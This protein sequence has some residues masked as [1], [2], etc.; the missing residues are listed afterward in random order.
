MNTDRGLLISF[1]GPPRSGRTY[2]ADRLAATLTLDGHDVVR[3]SMPDDPTPIAKTNLTWLQ[4]RMAA[5][6]S[7]AESSIR[8]AMERGAVVVLDGGVTS[9][10][11]RARAVMG[12]NVPLGLLYTFDVRAMREVPI[13]IEWIFLDVREGERRPPGFDC[14][15]LWR[16]A[17]CCH[18]RHAT[19]PDSTSCGGRRH[20]TYVLRAMH[21][22]AASEKFADIVANLLSERMADEWATAASE[23]REALDDAMIARRMEQWTLGQP[24]PVYGVLAAWTSYTDA[25]RLTIARSIPS[26][27]GAVERF[28]RVLTSLGVEQVA[29]EIN[30]V[31]AEKDAAETEPVIAEVVSI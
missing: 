6:A 12:A 4:E 17:A 28:V 9:A 13:D 25:Q 10:L 27:K 18:A 14:A 11:I 5:Y 16:A 1:D 8:P 19:F 23:T 3:V 26:H 20:A 22:D 30:A 15:G 2:Q 31:L 7:L 24:M 21:A 29:D